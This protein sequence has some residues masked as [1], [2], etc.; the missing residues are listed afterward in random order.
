MKIGR[1]KQ[2]PHRADY[3]QSGYQGKAG[4]RKIE[5]HSPDLVEQRM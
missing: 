2:I 5:V 3:T 4:I 1:Q